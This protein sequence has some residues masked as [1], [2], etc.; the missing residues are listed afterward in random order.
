MADQKFKV[1]DIVYRYNEKYKIVGIE[2]KWIKVEQSQ[3]RYIYMDDPHLQLT[4]RPKEI[5]SET[6]NE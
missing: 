3:I 4:A 5:V 1:G 6:G 2:D